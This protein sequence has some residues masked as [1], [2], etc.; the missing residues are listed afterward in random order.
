MAASGDR[1][2]WFTYAK[3]E[4]EPEGY[5]LMKSLKNSSF[6]LCFQARERRR[7]PLGS[8]LTIRLGCFDQRLRLS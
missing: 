6:F 7:K 1:K 2:V 4:S 3:D 5:I 8:V